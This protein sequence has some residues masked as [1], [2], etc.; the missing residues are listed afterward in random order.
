MMKMNQRRKTKIVC[1]I[2]PSTDS[3]EAIEK[4]AGL[5]M[6]VARINLSHGTPK[7]QENRSK[8]VN[9]LNESLKCKIACM[10]DTRGPEVR[11]GNAKE[12]VMLAEGSEIKV[13]WD[14]AETTAKGISLTYQDLD[15]VVSPHDKIFLADGNFELEVLE[16]KAKE[17]TC[18]VNTGGLLG[19]FKNVCIPGANL[20]LPTLDDLDLEYLKTGAK[21]GM[22]FV[23]QS[24]VRS[25]EDVMTLFEFLH[26]L[27][28]DAQ[29][30]AKIELGAA[31][32]RIERIISAS[33]GVMVARGDLGV[34]IP[35]EK[36]PIVQKEIIR[37]CNRQGKPVI[38]ATQMLESM[39]NNSR[40]TRAE[41]TDVANAV[42]D[43][44]DA[45]MLSGET[46]NGKFP[47]KAVQI[48]AQ[49][50]TEAETIY[51]PLVD[52]KKLAESKPVAAIAICHSAAQLAWELEASAILTP[53]Y[54]GFTPKHVSQLRP[55]TAILALTP[56]DRIAR[57]MSLIWGVETLIYSPKVNSETSMEM[58]VQEARRMGYVHEGEKVIVTSGIPLGLTGSTN[59]VHVHR[60][61]AGKN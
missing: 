17:I 52:Y 9:E 11:T 20:D 35:I 47:F 49:I 34:Q 28:S 57:K 10:Y 59:T 16:V 12:K 50:C 36:I 33:D 58:A 39:I 25:E 53:T 19:S 26:E 51:E 30:I 32:E 46:A 42:L 5:G 8:W 60:V 41:S 54:S 14:G 48:M 44:A 15:K 61:E 13:T 29:I 1:T 55:K 6:N 22:D 3:Y 31:V 27:G 2:G 43:G 18:R 7:E 24:F 45:V 56:Y 40:P 37:K 21:Y 23:A 38:V 4:L